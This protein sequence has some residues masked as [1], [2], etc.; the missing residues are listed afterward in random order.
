MVSR[1]EYGEASG[2]PQPD[3]Y[4]GFQSKKEW[5]RAIQR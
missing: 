4:A 5:E 3:R 1:G 2:V